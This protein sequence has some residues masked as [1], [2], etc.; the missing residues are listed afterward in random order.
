LI[1]FAPPRQLNRWV[2]ATQI[3]VSFKRRKTMRKYFRAIVLLLVVLTFSATIYPNLGSQSRRRIRRIADTNLHINAGAYYSWNVSVT[4]EKGAGLMGGFNAS[5]PVEF[6]ILQ[7]DEFQRW[8]NGESYSYIFA[9]G[10]V[11]NFAFDPPIGMGKGDYV[12]VLSNKFS[13]ITSKDVRITLDLD[14]PQ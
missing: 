6:Y 9:T 8:K 3:S 14:E 10:R 12:F 7:P 11:S 13:V 4:N 2:D 1:E 5:S